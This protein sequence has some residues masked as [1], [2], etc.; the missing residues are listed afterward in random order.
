MVALAAARELPQLSLEDALELTL[1]VARKDPRRH[2]RVA[3]RWLLR[4][5]ED[6][7]AATVEESSVSSL[8]R[9]AIRFPFRCRLGPDGMTSIS[10]RQAKPGGHAYLFGYAKKPPKGSKGCRKVLTSIMRPLC[11]GPARQE[12]P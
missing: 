11:R 12:S 9:K 6:D 4:Y 1:L 2:P 7:P 8:K 5:L 3:A 10:Q